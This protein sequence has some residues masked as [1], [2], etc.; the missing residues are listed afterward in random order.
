MGYTQDGR[1]LVLE[2]PLGK[3]VLLIQ[4]FQCTEM[5]SGL[6]TIQAKVMA[7]APNHTKVKA[8]AIIGKPVRIVLRDERGNRYFHGIVRRLIQTGREERFY[9]F[10]LEIVPPLWRLTAIQDSRIF[11]F[12]TIP[13]ILFEVLSERGI[14]EIEIQENRT[15]RTWDY[16]VQ[17]RESDF[18][19]LC[20]LM[21]QEGIYF[22]FKHTPEQ[23]RLI[24]ADD[25]SAHDP[26]PVQNE[27]LYVADAGW[28]GSVTHWESSEQLRPGLFTLR[29]HHF[30]LPT[31]S[32]EA[33]EPSTIQIGNNSALEIYD[34]PGEYAQLFNM[35]EERLDQVQ[36]EGESAVRLRMESEEA[37]HHV[38]RGTS[39]C[40]HLVSGH[41]F[42]FRE[43]YQWSGEYVVV[44]VQHHARQTPAYETDNPT[45]D[46]Y[47]NSFGCIPFKVP[48]RPPRRTPKPVV[49]GTQTA[50]VTGPSKEEIYVD[51]YGRV[52]VQFFWDRKGKQDEKSSCWV[53]VATPWAGNRWGMIHIPRIGQEVVVDFLEGDPDQPII[54]GSVWNPDQMPPYDL[55]GKMTQSGIKS[56]S[57][58]G[59]GGSN[60]NEIRFE[61]QKGSEEVYVHAERQMTTVVEANESRNVGGSRNTTIYKDDIE[62]VETGNHKLTVQK[63]N[64]EMDILLGNQV[65]F[66]QAGNIESQAPAGTH[67]MDANEI[68][69]SATTHLKIQCGASIIEM[70]PGTITISSPLVKIN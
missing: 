65:I 22:Y 8:D 27:L 16:C 41:K 9:Y 31:Q 26:C 32:L 28:Q 29:D 45:M 4:S 58:T 33:N 70:T 37:P 20:R 34:Y 55:P 6:Y 30:E 1:Y 36:S 2:T 54:V 51:K 43:H 66:V 69:L 50:M 35:P 3:D 11:Q 25:K 24:I 17:Y 46:F 68:L 57:T 42:T 61:D 7:E 52:K 67:R 38:A 62:V 19:F 53:R 5:I 15:H 39:H 48:Y 14:S 64:Q 49:H 13:Q 60:F 44:S 12:R 23:L 18:N 21:E 40:P 56:R 63:K 59:G 10:G 47:Q